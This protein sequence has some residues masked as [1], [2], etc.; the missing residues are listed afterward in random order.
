[1]TVTIHGNEYVTVAERVALLHEKLPDGAE[2]SIYTEIVENTEEHVIV[3]ATVRIPGGVFVG[4]AHSKKSAQSVEGQAPLE[5]AETSAVGRALGFAG[6]GAAESIASA[7]EVKQPRRKAAPKTKADAKNGDAS[8]QELIGQA[9]GQWPDRDPHTAACQALNLP[10]IKEGAIREHWL[11]KDGTYQ[12]AKAY[13]A[14]VRRLEVGGMT[15]ED[16]I[17]KVDAFGKLP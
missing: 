9:K 12:Q 8:A 4:H 5:V 16:A 13:I 14:E 17:Q 10:E 2:A 1:M 6:Y 3:K 11:G 7:D 15:L